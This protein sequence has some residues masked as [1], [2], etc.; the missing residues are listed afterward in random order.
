MRARDHMN[1][2]DFADLSGR[3][4]AGFGCG[5]DGTDVTARILAQYAE[6]Y[7]GQTIVI[8]GGSTS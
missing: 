5:L 4:G 6:K 8:D 3:F 2:G 1:G 7:V